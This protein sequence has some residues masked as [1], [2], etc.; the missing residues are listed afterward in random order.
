[1]SRRVR[2]CKDLKAGLGAGLFCQA[3]FGSFMVKE[4][5]RFIA[6]DQVN[7]SLGVLRILIMEV[8]AMLRVEIRI[9]GDIMVASENPLSLLILFG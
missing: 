9:K 4:C 2:G 5:N 3:Y 7:T 1:M 6:F 8:K